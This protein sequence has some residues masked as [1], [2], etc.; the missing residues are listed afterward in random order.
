MDHIS[1]INAA[2]LEGELAGREKGE[3]IG[4]EKGELVGR[5]KGELVGREKGEL[6]GREQGELVG[7]IHLCQSLLNQPITQKEKL[8]ALSLE[9]LTRLATDLRKQVVKP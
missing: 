3:L 8:L 9:E 7:T 1:A 2:R 4:R 5:E 6:I